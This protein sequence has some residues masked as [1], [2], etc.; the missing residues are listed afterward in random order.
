MR[1]ESI[2]PPASTMQNEY[3]PTTI[4]SKPTVLIQN[5]YI[6]TTPNPKPTVPHLL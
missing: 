3:I 4:I 1:N 2:P 6:T 5:E